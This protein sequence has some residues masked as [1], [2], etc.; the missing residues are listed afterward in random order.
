MGELLCCCRE[1]V[2]RTEAA[3]RSELQRSQVAANQRWEDCL[4]GTAIR[5]QTHAKFRIADDLVF[6]KPDRQRDH[7]IANRRQVIAG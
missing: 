1:A 3:L 5:H 2:D 4:R 6:A 7:V